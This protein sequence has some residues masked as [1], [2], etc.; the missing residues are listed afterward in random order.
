[1]EGQHVAVGVGRVGLV[2]DALAGGQLDG[3]RVAEAAHAAQ[4]AEV[5]IE[6]AVLLHHEDDVL[7]IF[8]GAGAV[9][10]RNRE[11]AGNAGGES[12]GC[13]TCRQKL[14]EGATVCTHRGISP[15]RITRGGNRVGQTIPRLFRLC[16]WKVA[17]V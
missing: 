5:V 6:G 3:A 16:D 14:E 9:V 11:R 10:S 15:L 7:H 8:N 1:M 12:R 2:P 17:I 13:C 4:R